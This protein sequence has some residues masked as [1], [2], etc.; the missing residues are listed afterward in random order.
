MKN[1]PDKTIYRHRHFLWI[2][3]AKYMRAWEMMDK[4]TEAAWAKTSMMREKG[5]LFET[6]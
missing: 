3:R 2:W 1:F 4:Y 6:P 5:W